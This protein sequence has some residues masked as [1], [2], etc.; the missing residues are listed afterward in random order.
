MAV[1]IETRIRPDRDTR[2]EAILDAAAEVFMEVGF[3][4]ASMSMIASRVGGSKELFEA[5]VR[6]HCAWQQEAIMAAFLAPGADL[7]TVLQT[8]G[9]N[10]LQVGLTGIGLRNFRLVVAESHRA[11]EIGRAFYE[12][13]P[14]TGAMRM[15]GGI[16]KA[17]ADGRL[18]PCDPMKAAHQFV[19]LCQNRMLKAC[20]CNAMDEPTLA[21]IDAEVAA[22]VETFLAAFGPGQVGR[23]DTADETRPE[24]AG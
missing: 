20:L 6:R 13:G 8:L 12:A 7:R 10:L 9:R 3:A 2:R 22:A 23:P 19:G 18:R 5:Y 1:A 24:A 15:A 11:P 17:V 21:E 16:A 14:G 4:A